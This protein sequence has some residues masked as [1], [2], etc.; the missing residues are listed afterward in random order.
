MC[1]RVRCSVCGGDLEACDDSPEECEDMQITNEAPC[2]HVC[3]RFTIAVARV[4]CNF[5]QQ[6]AAA[7]VL[8]FWLYAES[9]PLH[10]A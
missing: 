5:S 3:A 6:R 4:S 10:P 7:V 8:F 1:A 9:N 2:L